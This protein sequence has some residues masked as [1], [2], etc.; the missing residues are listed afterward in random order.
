M[1]DYKKSY[2][3]T[4]PDPKTNPP[5]KR[6]VQPD[7]SSSTEKEISEIRH[8][9]HAYMQGEIGIEIDEIL[10]YVGMLIDSYD[11][12]REI[13]E[14]LRNEIKRIKG[15]CQGLQPSSQKQVGGYVPKSAPENVNPPK[16]ESGAVRPGKDF[17]GPD[18]QTE[19]WKRK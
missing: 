6:V 2:T 9:Y 7:T 18:H 14:S 16:G 11:E 4:R 8:L 15:L 17:P 3:H 10:Y 13:A 5:S 19:G 12:Q 1:N